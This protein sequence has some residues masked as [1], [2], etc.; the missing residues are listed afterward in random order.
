MTDGAPWQCAEI[1]YLIGL[2]EVKVAVLA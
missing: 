2:D 1:K